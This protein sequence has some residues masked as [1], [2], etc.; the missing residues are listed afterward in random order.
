MYTLTYW[1]FGRKVIDH[2]R[3]K[4]VACAVASHLAR[5]T[6]VA[7]NVFERLTTPERTAYHRLLTTIRPR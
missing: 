4:R 3:D 1:Q 2:L 5:I 6:G 7:V